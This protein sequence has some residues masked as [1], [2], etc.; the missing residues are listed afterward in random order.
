MYAVD[1]NVVLIWTNTKA[2][3]MRS[4]NFKEVKQGF[5]PCIFLYM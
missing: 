3:T 2:C 1:A 4:H 5:S